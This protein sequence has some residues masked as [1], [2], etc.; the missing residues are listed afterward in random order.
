MVK[1]KTPKGLRLV[2]V[3]DGPVCV[4]QEELKELLDRVTGWQGT[5]EELE[6]TTHTLIKGYTNTIEELITVNRTNTKKYTKLKRRYTE[7]KTEVDH[8][9]LLIIEWFGAKKQVTIPKETYD[10]LLKQEKVKPYYLVAVYSFYYYTAIWQKTNQPKATI[11]YVSKGLQL[12]VGKVRE[13][14]KQLIK[15]GLI[16]DVVSKDESNK[17]TGHFMRVKYIPTLTESHRVEKHKAN[18]YNTNNKY[19]RVENLPAQ[20]T[21]FDTSKTVVLSYP[22]KCANRLYAAL[23]RKQK[24]MRPPKG[25]QWTEHFRKLVGDVSKKRIKPVLSWYIK[26]IGKLYVVKAY[27]AKSFCDNFIRIE[28]MMLQSIEQDRSENHSTIKVGKLRVNP[29]GTSS[30]ELEYEETE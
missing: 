23:K 12:S 11:A 16:E 8:Y 30:C 13:S 1:S 27:S 3:E 19:E 28:D 24:I 20:D 10:R 25:H 18:A 2:N 7:L 21:L 29:D 15:M 14:K 6:T 22:Q 4:D 26:N 17:I 5:I 9:K